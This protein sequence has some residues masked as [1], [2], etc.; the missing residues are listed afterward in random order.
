MPSF[1]LLKLKSLC[2]MDY[3]LIGSVCKLILGQGRLGLLEN[4]LDIS[5]I[6]EITRL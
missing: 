6:T 1:H 3:V 5:S 2:Q 4:V